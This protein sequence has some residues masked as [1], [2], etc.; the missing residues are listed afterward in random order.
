MRIKNIQVRLFRLLTGISINLEDDITLVVGRNNTGKTSLLEVIKSFTSGDDSISFEDFSQASYV[1]FKTLYNEYLKT[2]APEISDEDKEAIE[3]QIIEQFPKIQLQ[4]EFTYDKLKDSLVE[5][6]E[7]ITDLDPDRNDA[8]V[9]LSYESIN[10]LGLL[11][12][13]HNREER[14][15]DL[16]PYLKTNLK[17]FY[18]L[19]CY[20][21]DIKSDYLRE[22][23]LGYK[24][25]IKRVVSFEDIQA[26]RVLDDKKNDKN[27][28]LASGFSKYYNE[29]DKT[30]ANVQAVEAKLKEVSVDLKEKYDAVLEKILE[31]LKK[32]GAKTPIVIPDITIDSEFDSEAV[33]RNNIKYY[34]KQEEI[35]LPESYNGLGYSNLIYMI[36]ELASFIE[37]FR[38]AKDKK[39]SEFLT[40]LIEEPEAHMHPQMQQVFISQIKQIIKDAKRDGIIVQLL[41]TSHSSHILSEAGI[42]SEKGF[43]RI[44]YFNRE[45]S[46]VV[47]QD[48]NSLK[49]S[50]EKNTARFLKQYLTLHKSDLFFSDKVIIVEGTTERMLMPQLIKKSAPSLAT[51]YVSILEV[52]GA[53]TH[54]FKEILE[55]LKLK[56]LV[57]TDIDSV[58]PEDDNKRCPVNNGINGEVT[59][60]ETLKEWIP[61]KTTITDLIACTEAD[62]IDGA[63]IRVAYQ[64]SEN[65][66][67]GRSFEEAFI[68]TNKTLIES[69][70]TSAEGEEK[71]VK[72]LFSFGRN[73]SLQSIKDMS[74]YDLA[75]TS[76][77]AKTNF[78]FDVMSFPEDETLKWNVPAYIDEGLKWLVKPITVAEVS[79]T[80]E[81]E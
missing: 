9:L 5:L 24:D 76:S 35:N 44:R 57:I 34:Y 63:L 22:I 28:T 78:A 33:I 47:V 31:D 64:T 19:K 66:T 77:S 38:N 20:A 25:K 51:E 18:R 71:D 15:I 11:N 30:D 41:I 79:V 58:N 52:G 70:Y 67:I 26:L 2:L 1:I 29:R 37:K 27:K 81:E 14:D 49:I 46:G 39:V 48:F 12:M 36:L 23:E 17:S 45:E 56:T 62:K 59:S 6:S 68:S 54:K 10:G 13:F 3:N 65:E 74:C 72:N 7:F 8:C 73:K 43:K 75:P 42:D 32:F 50:N 53:Y 55:F 69:Q 16:I 40:V 4:I 21:K 60:N 80:N 61:N